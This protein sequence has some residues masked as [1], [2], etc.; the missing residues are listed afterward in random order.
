MRRYQEHYHGSGHLWQGRFKSFPIE[1]DS[2]LLTVLR[3]A[4]RNPVRAE[5]V[6]RAEPW[7]WSS[8]RYWE[9]TDGRPS[10]LI[11]GPVRRPPDW[12]GWVNAAITS[13]EL[14]RLRRSVNRGT[15]FGNEAWMARTAEQLGLQSTLRPRGRPRKNAAMG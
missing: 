13:S 8:A 9:K 14:E 6:E 4:E 15:P 1:D 10:Y 5:L 3:Y 7:Q 12:L 11:P 2:H